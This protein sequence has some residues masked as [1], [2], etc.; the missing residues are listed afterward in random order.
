[1]PRSVLSASIAPYQVIKPKFES[2]TSGRRLALAQWLTQPNHPLTSRVMVNRI[3]QGH[4]GVGLIASPANLGQTGLAR[5]VSNRNPPVEGTGVGH[6]LDRSV[7]RSTGFELGR[8]AA[9]Q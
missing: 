3:W 9:D 1:M 6:G 7:S 4:F 8:S 2:D 5:Q